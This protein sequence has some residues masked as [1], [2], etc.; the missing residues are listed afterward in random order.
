MARLTKADAA[1]QL[2]LSRTTLDT[3][4]DQGPRRATPALCDGM[5][6]RELTKHK[7]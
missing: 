5:K 4:I 3:L 2:G 6:H 7:E 1:R